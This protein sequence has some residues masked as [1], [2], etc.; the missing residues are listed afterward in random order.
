KKGDPKDHGP[1][2]QVRLTTV[3]DVAH[4]TIADNG[5]IVTLTKVCES[6]VSQRGVGAMEPNYFDCHNEE[7]IEKEVGLQTRRRPSTAA[8]LARFGARLFEIGCVEKHVLYQE[9]VRLLSDLPRAGRNRIV[10]E[11]Q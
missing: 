1:Q 2:I 8:T 3:K 7:A 5:I 4:L 11:E 10:T 9:I 6:M